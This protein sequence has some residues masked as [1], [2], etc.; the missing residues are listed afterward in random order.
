MFG[1][2]LVKENSVDAFFNQTAEWIK[3]LK[4]KSGPLRGSR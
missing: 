3:K 1:I 4:R 2:V